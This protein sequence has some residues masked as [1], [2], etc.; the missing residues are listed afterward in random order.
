[1]LLPQ[2]HT[3][4]FFSSTWLHLG[5]PVFGGLWPMDD[6]FTSSA[7]SSAAQACA[8]LD[9]WVAPGTS[10]ATCATQMFRPTLT[11]SSGT[12]HFPGRVGIMKCLC[13]RILFFFFWVVLHLDGR[14][15]I[16]FPPF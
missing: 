6:G 8:L 16:L 4:V 9:H 15:S 5:A 12:L 1:M 14:V 10:D 11:K 7:A 2:Q 3:G 13:S